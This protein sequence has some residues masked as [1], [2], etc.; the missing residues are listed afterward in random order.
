MPKNPPDP[1]VWVTKHG[2]YL[3][4][5]E[6][7]DSHITNVINMLEKHKNNLSFEMDNNPFDRGFL[8]NNLN[9]SI[10]ECK[11]KIKIFKDEM[12]WRNQCKLS[13]VNG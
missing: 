10:K 2:E 12:K 3:R 13:S 4:I 1:I 9:E 11:K 8:I 5:S 7:S 6:M